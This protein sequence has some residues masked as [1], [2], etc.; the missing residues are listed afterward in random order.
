MLAP[1]SW[2]LQGVLSRTDEQWF[3]PVSG[4]R[5]QQVLQFRLGCHALPVAADRL[6][7]ASHVDRANRVCLVC[8]SGAIGN[9]KQMDVLPWL[10]ACGPLHTSV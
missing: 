8:N 4:R 7:G 6:A 10:P 5:I 3:E 2:H 9:G 1:F